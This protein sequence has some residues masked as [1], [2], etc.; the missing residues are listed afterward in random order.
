VSE[1]VVAVS[2]LEIVPPSAEAEYE[3]V[4][5]AVMPGLEGSTALALPA[6]PSF[7]YW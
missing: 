5:P 3:R 7:E 1:L 6:H 2:V 4:G